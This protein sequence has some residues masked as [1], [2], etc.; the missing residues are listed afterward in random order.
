MLLYV[1]SQH[2]QPWRTIY[3]TVVSNYFSSSP[4]DEEGTV[5]LLKGNGITMSD[6]G[7]ESAGE[8]EKEKCFVLLKRFC[9]LCTFWLTYVGLADEEQPLGKDSAE[10][11]KGKKSH[12]S[13]SSSLAQSVCPHHILCL[14]QQQKMVSRGLILDNVISSSLSSCFFCSYSSLISGLCVVLTD[15]VESSTPTTERP[16]TSRT[17]SFCW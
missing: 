11:E 9:G 14:S 8:E 10:D 15:E 2:M 7:A 4:S 16:G 17:Q 12:P 3:L 1:S 13:S 6:T 5:E